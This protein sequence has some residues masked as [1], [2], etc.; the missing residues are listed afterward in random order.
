MARKA[1]KAKD[2][3]GTSPALDAAAALVPEVKATIAGRDLVFREYAVFEGYE[4]AYLARDF[5]AELHQQLKGGALKYASVRRLIGPHQAVIVKIAAQSADVDEAWVRG[6][7][8]ESADQFFAS[9]FVATA[10][11]FV[12]EVLYDIQQERAEQAMDTKST[13]SSFASVE[14]TSETSN[15]SSAAP[16]VN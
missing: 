3:A 13:G 11:F 7:D 16:S 12:R 9:W 2:S 5:I 15:H 8:R 1:D 10:G 6:L 14:R 4:V